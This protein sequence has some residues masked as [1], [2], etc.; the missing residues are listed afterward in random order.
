MNFNRLTRFLPFRREQRQAPQPI[1][2]QG[3]GAPNI[4]EGA[5][6]SPADRVILNHDNADNNGFV[7]IDYRPLTYAEALSSSL[8]SARSGDEDVNSANLNLLRTPQYPG[9]TIIKY[10]S[11][12]E[13]LR[14]VYDLDLDSGLKSALNEK[15]QR[16]HKAIYT[17]ENKKKGKKEYFAKQLS[18]DLG[19]QHS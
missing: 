15:V 16:K 8:N 4:P 17:R 19:H 5:P 2:H 10:S 13:S 11:T 9:Q 3:P 6:L 1:Q 18:K 7:Q 14:N 12:A